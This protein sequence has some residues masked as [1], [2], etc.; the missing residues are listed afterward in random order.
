M[1]AQGTGNAAHL[2]HAVPPAPSMSL[3][4]QWAGSVRVVVASRAVDQ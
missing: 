2:A 4:R 1:P 3:T